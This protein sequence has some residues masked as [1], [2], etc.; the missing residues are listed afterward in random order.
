MRT[1]NKDRAYEEQVELFERLYNRVEHL[2]ENF[3]RPDYLPDYPQGDYSVHGD[4]TGYP[5]VVIFVRNLELLKPEIVSQLQRLVQEFPGWQIV[6]TVAV[7]GHDGDWPDMGLYV[8]PHEIID[9]LQRQFFPTEFKDIEYEG[10]RKGTKY[11]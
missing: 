5:Q 10:A 2:L 7:R 9:G 6:M 4:Y 1:I 3:G 11:D 8:R